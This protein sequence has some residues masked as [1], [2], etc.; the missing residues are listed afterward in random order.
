MYVSGESSL[1]NNSAADRGGMR[2][3]H[4]QYTL[5]KERGER[6]PRKV[7]P[8]DGCSY[9]NVSRDQ[10]VSYNSRSTSNKCL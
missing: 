5:N 2:L 10:A 7:A 8:F 3:K 4:V 6:L 9:I 1:V